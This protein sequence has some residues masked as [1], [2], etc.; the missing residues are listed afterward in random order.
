MDAND[1]LK[2]FLTRLAEGL[3]AVTPAFGAALAEAGAICL[4]DQHHPQGVL[5][6]IEGVFDTAFSLHWQEVTDQ[7]RRCW[8]DEEYTTEQAAYGITFLLLLHLTEFTVIERSRKGSGFDYW[9]GTRQDSELPFTNR[10]R[11]EVSGIR[12]GDNN[13]IRSRARQKLDQTKRSDGRLPAYIFV[14]EFSSPLAFVT[15]K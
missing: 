10:V 14:I 4:Q 1:T 5:I 2:L 6:Q 7:M 13:R 12:K 9:L 8:N 3:P 11:L 15:Q